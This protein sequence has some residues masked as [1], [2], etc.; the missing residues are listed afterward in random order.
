MEELKPQIV[1]GFGPD[2]ITGNSD[3]RYTGMITDS[4]FDR[5]ECGRILLHMAITKPLPPY[6]AYGVAVP[7]N[8]VDLKV[9]VS[10]YFG[11]RIRAVESHKTQFSQRTRSAYRLFVHTMRKEK[12]IIASN[13]GGDELLKTA[14]K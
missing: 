6:Y 12:Y 2:G 1:I 14:F 4:A 3:H 13:R 7:R 9:H 10:R 8:K 5:T 11:Q